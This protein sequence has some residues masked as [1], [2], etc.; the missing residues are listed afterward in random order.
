[1]SKLIETDLGPIYISMAINCNEYIKKGKGD[2]IYTSI[3]CIAGTLKP[4]CADCSLVNPN[5]RSKLTP[6]SQ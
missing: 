1:M 2:I 5:N 3:S 6:T 4:E